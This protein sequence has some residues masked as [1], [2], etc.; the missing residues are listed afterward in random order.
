MSVLTDQYDEIMDDLGFVAEHPKA[1]MSKVDVI[2]V[3]GKEYLA[4]DKVLEIV[5]GEA[6]DPDPEKD[7]EGCMYS[8][9]WVECGITIAEMI[10][11]LKG[12]VKNETC[13]KRSEET[14]REYKNSLRGGDVE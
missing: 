2:R 3:N 14:L 9:G 5:E 12:D 1:D 7:N 4:A 11:A 10:R 6:S 8:E 13:E